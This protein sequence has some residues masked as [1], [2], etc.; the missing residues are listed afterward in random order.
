M[1]A[2]YKIVFLITLLTLGLSVSITFVNY[3]I[4]FKNAENQLITQSLPL[5]VDNIYTDIQKHVIEPY[6]ISSMMANDTFC[7][8]LV[9]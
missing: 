1:K 4:S 2:N 5:S 8:R 6:L 7:K 9:S 3:M